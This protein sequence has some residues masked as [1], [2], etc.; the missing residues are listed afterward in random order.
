M[1]DETPATTPD[2]ETGAEGDVDQLS[3][4]DTL[5]DRGYDQLDEGYSPLERPR[6]NHWGETPWEE[7][8]DEPLDQR[9]TQEEPD[10]WEEDRHRPRDD[11]RAGRLVQMD[12]DGDGFQD[13]DVYG[14]DAGIDG[15]A[16]TAE[17]AAIHWVEEP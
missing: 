5:L 12:E 3:A 17:E 13:N 9:L 16:A 7:V 14:V 15:A 1:T 11:T 8:R 2:P 6:P 10:W 4:E